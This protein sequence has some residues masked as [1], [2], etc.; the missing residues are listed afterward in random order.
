MTK[1]YDPNAANPSRV[2][3][4]LR[5]L[6]Q[7]R[8]SAPMTAVEPAAEVD[9]TPDDPGSGPMRAPDPSR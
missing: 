6:G 8:D 3:E 2:V 5:Q 1:S 9:E 7:R 4:L